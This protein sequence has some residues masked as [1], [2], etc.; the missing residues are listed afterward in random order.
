MENLF[1]RYLHVDGMIACNDLV[2]ISTYKAL[3]KRHI[4]VPQDV[5]IIGFDDIDAAQ[6]LTP[7]LT[8]LRQPVG[9]MAQRVVEL[10]TQSEEQQETERIRVFPV[11]LIIRETTNRKEEQI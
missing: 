2:A 1:R 6:L 10:L 4:R 7:S 11:S 9:E 8:T 3:Y 5:Q